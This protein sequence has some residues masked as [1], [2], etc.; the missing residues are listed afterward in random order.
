MRKPP[1]HR[2]GIC[3]SQIG[4]DAPDRNMFSQSSFAVNDWEKLVSKMAMDRNLEEAWPLWMVTGIETRH[5]PCSASAWRC[6]VVPFYELVTEKTPPLRSDG[7]FGTIS[8]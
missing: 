5:G 4:A 6:G 3:V 2:R 1:H 7:T 8:D